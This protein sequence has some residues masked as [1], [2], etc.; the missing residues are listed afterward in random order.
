MA[1]RLVRLSS[2]DIPHRL[3]YFFEQ[4]EQ[5]R[6]SAPRPRRSV[7]TV[8]ERIPSMS[9]NSSP[10]IRH[11]IPRISRKLP[12][13]SGSVDLLSPASIARPRRSISP[14]AM[15]VKI[16][17]ENLLRHANG[18]VATED[19]VLAWLAWNPTRP[20]LLIRTGRRG[21]FSRT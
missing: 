5:L 6:P 1:W 13:A 14:A 4:Y 11:S 15:T 10:P 3:K 20:T 16:V 17:L 21:F 19:D 7:R 9:G 8:D 12:L 18:K 2:L